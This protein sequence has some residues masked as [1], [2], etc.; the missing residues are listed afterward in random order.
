MTGLVVDDSCVLATND[1]LFLT[2]IGILFNDSV[3]SRFPRRFP[4]IKSHADF[5]RS[6]KR[7]VPAYQLAG[8]GPPNQRGF[9]PR[10]RREIQFALRL[11]NYQ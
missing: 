11:A 2:Q 7:V 9:N 1:N 8:L 3:T 4:Q 10:N 6:L 5:R